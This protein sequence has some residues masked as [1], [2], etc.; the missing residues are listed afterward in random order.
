MA[1]SIG[2]IACS[3]VKGIAPAQKMRLD[4]WQVPGISGY[5]AQQL[6]GGDS[7]CGFRCI[8]V[9][10]S[11]VLD[12]WEASIEAL[13]GAIVNVVND[14]GKTYTG[15]LVSKV[16]IPQRVPAYPDGEKSTVMVQGVIC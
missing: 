6:G 12:A 8:Q 9:A 7:G 13:Q 4:I 10:A 1:G 5:G 15:F 14:R 2:G 3:W 11:A 16:G